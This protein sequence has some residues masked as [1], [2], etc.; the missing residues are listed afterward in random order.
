MIRDFLSGCEASPYFEDISLKNIQIRCNLS[1]FEVF[2][3]GRH[4]LPK[5]IM[6]VS[7]R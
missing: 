1:G 2:A 5:S 7:S 3:I 6:F 4:Y